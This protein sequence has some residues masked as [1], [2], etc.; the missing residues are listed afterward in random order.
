M[1][2]PS[3]HFRLDALCGVECVDGMDDY[4]DL[5]AEQTDTRLHTLVIDK[6][7]D[8]VIVCSKIKHYQAVPITIRQ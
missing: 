8:G 5:R 6:S 4:T 2:F 3:C 1:L 7:T